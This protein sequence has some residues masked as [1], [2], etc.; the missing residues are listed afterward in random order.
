VNNCSATGVEGTDRGS[1]RSRRG[2]VQ[3]LLR[4]SAKVE[5]GGGAMGCLSRHRLGAE[6]GL[7]GLTP[8]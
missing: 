1:S 8:G 3:G 5:A 7:G 4:A 2:L 6:Q